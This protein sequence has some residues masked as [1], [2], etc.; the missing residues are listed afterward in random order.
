MPEQR[1]TINGIGFNFR[2]S[3][4]SRTVVK[5]LVVGD[6]KASWVDKYYNLWNVEIKPT[7]DRIKRNQNPK[8][9]SEVIWE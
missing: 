8:R 4:P 1:I 6:R 9:V 5:N 2:P 7:Y 3:F